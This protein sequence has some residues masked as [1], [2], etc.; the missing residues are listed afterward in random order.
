MACSINSICMGNSCAGR[1]VLSTSESEELRRMASVLERVFR[2][3]VAYVAMLGRSDRVMSR[4]GSG[5]PYWKYLR[6]L[7]LRL[8]LSGPVVVRDAASGLPEGADF[9]EIHFLAG[10]PLRTFCGEALGVVVIA[11]R[12]PRPEFARPDLDLLI[13]LAEGVRNWL[14]LRMVACQSVELRAEL[15]EAEG[16]FRQAANLASVPLGYFGADGRCLFV[17]EAW[18]GYTGG[19]MQFEKGDGWCEAIHP[20]Q[21]E[22]VQAACWR[23]SQTRRG[24][25]MEVRFRRYDG[26]FRWMRCEAAPRFLSDGEPSGLVVSLNEIDGYACGTT[27]VETAEAGSAVPPTPAGGD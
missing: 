15:A 20:Q 4:F 27:G 11:D 25:S 8:Y 16:R 13:D 17:N 19:A 3:P 26:A 23:A 12:A 6:T 1:N 21:R 10:V 22:S 2:V 24:F 5:E 9:G 7:P 18:L 14:E